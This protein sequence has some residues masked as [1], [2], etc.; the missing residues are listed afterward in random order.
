MSNHHRFGTLADGSAVE[1]V[2]IA[3]GGLAATVLTYG[4]V[5][6]D[7]RLAGHQPP[8]VLGFET[9]A[10]Y[11]AHSRFFG[12]TAGRCANRIRDG[13][14]TLD[15]RDYQLDCNFLG[16]H[17]LHGGSG[18][19]GKRVWT[20]EDAQADR[21]ALSIA[22]TDGEMGYPGAMTIRQVLS[23]PGDG[24]LDIRLEAQSDAP[25]LCNLAHHSYFNL[26]GS[27]TILDHDLQVAA[28]HYLPVDGEL[29]PT[30]E[31]APVEG[32]AFDF[33]RPRRLREVCAARSID[34]NF[35]LSDRRRDL[36]RVATLSAPASGISMDILTTEPGLQVYDGGPLDV[37][38]PGLD[39]RRIGAHAGMA[40]EPQV[41][42][43]AINH[44][45][46][47]QA[48]MRPGETYRQHTQF[49]FRKEHG[50]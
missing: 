26:D 1:A 42:P 9:L 46:F 4:A 10:D 47:P 22:L 41:W 25:T 12:A 17:H 40:L 3:G 31:V 37:P 30:G 49:V 36:T 28:D 23:L 7:L 18:N 8:L 35:C 5:L 15:G 21:V 48:V 43:D 33:R 27:D 11:L 39:G 50:A 32:D 38:V 2:R 45:A 16:K 24:V 6:Q 13:R 44:P 29:I 19:I 34:H 20:L 14:F